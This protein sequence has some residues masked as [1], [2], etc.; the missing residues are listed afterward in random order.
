MDVI[1]KASFVKPMCSVVLLRRPDHRWPLIVGANRDEMA[2]RPWLPPGRH[3][4]DRPNVVAGLDELAGGTWFGLNDEG[5]VACILNRHGTLGPQEGK[6]S[7]G[8]LVLEA[9]DHAD[10]ADAAL[11]LSQLDTRAYRSFN[12]VIADNRDAYL[13]MNRGDSPR[14]RPEV[15]EIPEGVH[16]VTAF[17]MDDPADARIGRHLPEFRNAPPPD[18][19]RP[20]WGGWPAALASREWQGSRGEG[21]AM[22]FRL[23]N[24]FGTLCSS[25]L[26]LPAVEHPE[27]DPI[28]H[29]AAGRPSETGWTPVEGV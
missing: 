25:L 2:G 28:W 29:F 5:V 27:L 1:L 18:P 20:D 15:L 10:A 26:A 24:G 11:A 22:D 6:R 9:L 14:H 3:W 16:M 7:R 4:P 12:L 13:L 23:P 17:D 21:G 19:D 8:E